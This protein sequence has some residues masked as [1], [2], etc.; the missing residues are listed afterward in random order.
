MDLHH[1]LEDNSWPEENFTPIPGPSKSSS[2]GEENLSPQRRPFQ[3][4]PNQR[5]SRKRRMDSTIGDMVEVF[6]SNSYQRNNL[7]GYYM[8]REQRGSRP[9]LD[10]YDDTDIYF[11]GIA[12]S[13]KKLRRE[14]KIRL[15]LLISKEVLEAELNEELE[16]S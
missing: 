10:D 16:T 14:Q 15:K 2:P 11:I 9:P 4:R 13:V 1:D 7:I 3:D 12:R 6:R 8:A 5:V